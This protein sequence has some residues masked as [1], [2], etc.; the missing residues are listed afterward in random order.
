[1]LF[2][3]CQQR[4]SSINNAYFLNINIFCVFSGHARPPNL[5]SHVLQMIFLGDT[6]FH[7]PFAHFPT[8]EANAS[9]IYVLYWDAVINLQKWGFKVNLETFQ[10]VNMSVH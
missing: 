7:F 4:K 1:M 6:N 2:F 3:L 9:D 8:H 5:A 10:S